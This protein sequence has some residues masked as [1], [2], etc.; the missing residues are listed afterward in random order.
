MAKDPSARYRSA[1]LAGS[2]GRD[3]SPSSRSLADEDPLIDQAHDAG[4]AQVPFADFLAQ[5]PELSPAP[6]AAPSSPAP[7]SSPSTSGPRRLVQGTAAKL[8]GG[9][10]ESLGAVLL[11]ILLAT[12]ALSVLDY[13]PKGPLLWFEAK[14][15]N[16]AV[17]APGS[18]SS[19]STG[20]S[21]PPSNPTGPAG[22]VGPTTG[23]LSYPANADT[24]AG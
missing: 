22:P 6:P 1:H 16:D 3:L 21:G 19:S 2:E 15:L 8:S 23:P 18:S 5:H 4:R 11:G 24:G 17:A 9:R 13:G 7:S 20:P 10:T 12:L 14:F